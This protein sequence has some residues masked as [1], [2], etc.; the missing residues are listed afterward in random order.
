MEKMSHHFFLLHLILNTILIYRSFF[1]VSFSHNSQ[2]RLF[3]KEIPSFKLSYKKLLIFFVILELLDYE[4][5]SNAQMF[6]NLRK[7]SENN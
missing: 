5:L 4:T 6:I 1:A 3:F 2:V 7:N